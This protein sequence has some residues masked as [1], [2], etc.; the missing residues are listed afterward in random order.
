MKMQIKPI[1]CL[2]ILSLSF[3]LSSCSSQFANKIRQVTYPPDFNYTEQTNLRSDM[4]MLAQQMVL[5]ERSLDQVAENTVIAREAQRQD[6][7]NSLKEMQRIASRLKAGNA[8]ANHPFMDD[9]M[10]TFITKVDQARGAA[11]I[12]PPRY[13]FAGKVSGACTNCHTV[14]R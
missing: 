13:Y 9:Y 6:V 1:Y 12:D 10:Q 2:F 8:G 7:L 3:L 11:S 4:A 14:N 5:L